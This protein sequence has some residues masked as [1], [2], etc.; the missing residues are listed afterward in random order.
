MQVAKKNSA[1]RKEAECRELIRAAHTINMF[2]VRLKNVRA[3]VK[4]AI[5][6]YHRWYD[7]ENNSPATTASVDILSSL[8]PVGH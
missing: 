2:A 3:Q 4:S 6:F 5:L 8:L 1:R 7:S